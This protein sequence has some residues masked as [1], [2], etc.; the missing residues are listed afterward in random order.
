MKGLKS[1]CTIAS[2][3]IGTVIGAGFASGQEI[4]QFFGKHGK[5]GV[6][7]IG[8]STL[9]L[10]VVAVRT[11]ETVYRKKIRSFEDYGRRYFHKKVFNGFN[12]LVA[13]LLLVGYFVMLAGS[14]AVIKENFQIPA[15]YG[16]LIMS[17]FCFSVFTFGIDGVAKA[18]NIV[19]PFL[20]G[21]VFFVSLSVLIKNKLLFSNLHGKSFVALKGINTL[22]LEGGLIDFFLLNL[23]WVK[24]SLLY[25]AHNSIG[26]I[27]VITSLLPYI[28][29]AKA[30]KWG[31]VL[32]GLGLGF[33]ALLILLSLLLLYTDIVGLE[34]PMVAIAHSLS[35]THKKIYSVVL[36]L[37]MFTTAIANGYGCILRFSY[38]MKLREG[39]ARI[40]VCCLSIPLATLGF[41]NLVS[42]FY[43][44]FGYVGFLFIGVF[45]LKT[46]NN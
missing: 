18:N 31:G 17:V 14:G 28:H 37:A 29:N 11:L 4:L 24:S 27:I 20:L 15:I 2:V 38:I 43:P 13:F 30:A 42:F 34:V 36:L 19:V 1:I 45:V 25:A 10:V 6:L 35:E 16:I 22:K 41:K 9:I 21:V 46:N 7:G 32:G 3:Y 26:A 5:S 23:G 39:W 44:L 8:F 40:L 12:L 33:V